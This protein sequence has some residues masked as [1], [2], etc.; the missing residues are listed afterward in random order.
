MPYTLTHIGGEH[1]VTGSCHLLQA[2][3]LNILVDCG[4]C[5]GA[6]S[7]LPLDEWPVAPSAIDFLFLT[8]AH[9]D[10]IGR[11]PELIA[12]GFSGEILCTHATKALL[13]P[14]L[15][16]ALSFTRM[17]GDEREKLL[18]NLEEISWGFEYKEVF[19]LRRGITFT[20]GR[21]GHILGSCWIR[22]DLP[23][24]ESIVFSGDLGARNTPILPDPDIPAPCDLLVMESTYGDRRHEER[25]NR[26]GRLESILE[27]AL[28]DNGK[29]LIP[30]FALGRTQELLYELD[31]LFSNPKSS[32]SKENRHLP[33]FID[34]PLGLAITRIYSDLTEGWDREAK[35]LLANADHPLDFDH[36]YGV[37]SFTD[38]QQLLEL[39]GP[40]IIIA[41]SGMCSGGRI[42]A[43]LKRHLDD[44]ATDILFVGYQAPGTTG[45][46]I[47]TYAGKPGG[48]VMLDGE[49]CR[50]HAS[51]HALGGYSAHADG[52]ELLQWAA[53]VRPGDVK[54]VHGEAS[55]QA[56]LNRLI[57]SHLKSRP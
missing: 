4:I 17:G 31:R 41:G 35:A 2:E 5:Q 33:V 16:D 42:V 15:E 43:H 53:A 49:S 10:H 19:S 21:A 48:H 34:S 47:L 27:K 1:T 52:E 9:I 50:I 32:F 20:L 45:R 36:L 54:L 30:A 23:K 38:H 29:V 14:M 11:V 57:Q 55:A 24:K 44:P 6:D 18:S 51:V 12:S 26:I 28:G 46:D 13:S 39:N 8:H 37:A 56:H 7:A 40:A 22:F 3:G 25:G